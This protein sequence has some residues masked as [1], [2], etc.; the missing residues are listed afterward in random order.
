VRALKNNAAAATTKII[1]ASQAERIAG[2][3][4]ERPRDMLKAWTIQ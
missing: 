4:P 3:I 1:L 2:N